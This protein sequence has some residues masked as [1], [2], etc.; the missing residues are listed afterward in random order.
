MTPKQAIERALELLKTP[1]TNRP[2]G[3][4][5]GHLAVD[6]NNTSVAPESDNAVAYCEYGALK[7][8]TCFIYDDQHFVDICEDIINGANATKQKAEYEKALTLSG[9]RTNTIFGYN[10]DKNARNFEQVV[11]RF[12]NAIDFLE[13]TPELDTYNPNVASV[14]VSDD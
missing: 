2:H 14:I 13:Q 1:S 5:Q 4:V 10:D 8:A 7:A 6:I 11:A 3:W 12:Q 9:N